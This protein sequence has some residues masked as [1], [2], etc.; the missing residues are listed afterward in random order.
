M[1]A[2]TC[3]PCMRYDL[4]KNLPP[5]RPECRATTPKH[6]QSLAHG[7]P[8]VPDTLL[9]KYSVHFPKSAKARHTWIS[10]AAG[11][12]SDEEVPSPEPGVSATR[13]IDM[14]HRTNSVSVCTR[15]TTVQSPDE[16]VISNE[17]ACG[18]AA[19]SA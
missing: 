1:S 15:G 7:T 10:V 13:R 9:T 14:E 17:N 18:I 19:E 5:P 16:R 3:K 11:F 8:A 12:R 6:S 4:Q 2:Y